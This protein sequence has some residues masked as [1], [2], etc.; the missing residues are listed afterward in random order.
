MATIKKSEARLL[1]FFGILMFIAVTYFVLDILK[2]K[3]NAEI[4]RQVAIQKKIDEYKELIQQKVQW[5][6]KRDF[7]DQYQPRYRSEEV[8]APA[9]E[10]YFRNHAAA[11]N[12]TVTTLLPRAPEP[13]GENMIALSLEAKISGTGQDIINFLTRLQSERLFYAIP[14]ISIDADRKDPSSVK[15]DM[16]FSRWYVDEGDALGEEP[17]TEPG[18]EPAADK[19]PAASVAELKEPAA[20]G[21]ASN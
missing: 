6:V 19:P 2:A 17:T 16:I 18:T 5:E 4:I 10:A 11:A 12:V 20:A 3:R 13:L 1:A 9:L 14:S 7:V 8:E 15:A 21:A